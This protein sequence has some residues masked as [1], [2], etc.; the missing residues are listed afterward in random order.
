MLACSRP[1]LRAEV[2]WNVGLPDLAKRWADAALR[3]DPESKTGRLIAARFLWS[4]GR[5]D[6]ARETLGALFPRAVPLADLRL[7][8][9]A[10]LSQRR[11]GEAVRF[12][13]RLAAE[14]PNDPRILGRLIVALSLDGKYNRAARIAAPL[15]DRD[16]PEGA[17]AHAAM[18]VKLSRDDHH[19][20]ALRHWRTAFRRVDDLRAELPVYSMLELHREYGR[21]ALEVG[22]P[23]ESLDQ[24]NRASRI[25]SHDYASMLLRARSLRDLGRFGSAIDALE[26]L[27]LQYP[28]EGAGLLE[29]G[30][31]LLQ[32]QRADEAIPRLR[33]AARLMPDS[34]RTI[35]ALAQA[36]R[37][38][39]P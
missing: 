8:G 18:A 19:L 14:Y 21:S 12:H 5:S 37:W 34:E 28:S 10:L 30:L 27:V 36:L 25:D 33:E 15:L 35:Y 39:S 6:E 17:L 32:Q 23:Q 29:L 4:H 9:Q 13:Q 31:A 7:H 11:F 3:S 22:F 1:A 20:A 16:T 26:A 38:R 2:A 24:A